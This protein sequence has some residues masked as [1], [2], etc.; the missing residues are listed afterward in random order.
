[1]HGPHEHKIHPS[2][3]FV[4]FNV[5][6]VDEFYALSQQKQALK[7]DPVSV[8]PLQVSPVSPFPHGLNVNWILIIILMAFVSRQ[9]LFPTSYYVN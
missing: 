3:T 1:M 4:K 9:W 7:S 2:S 6:L 5:I 8:R